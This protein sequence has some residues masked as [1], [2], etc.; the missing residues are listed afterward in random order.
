M[1]KMKF[2]SDLFKKNDAHSREMA[3]IEGEAKAF[4]LPEEWPLTLLKSI[5]FAGLA[6]LNYH[7]FQKSIPGAWGHGVGF[8]AILSEVYVIYA[9][10]NFSRTA[11]PFQYC[12]GGFGGALLVF[13]I[14]HASFSVGDLMSNGAPSAAFTEYARDYAFRI[15][16]ILL[17]AATVVTAALHPK[18]VI[19]FKQAAAHTAIA[20]SRAETA[21][22]IQQMKDQDLVEEARFSM[23]QAKT[24][25]EQRYIGHI[26][27]H[28]QIEQQK[29]DLVNSISDPALRAEAAAEYGVDPASLK[30]LPDQTSNR[31]H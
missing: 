27:Q 8:T 7:L 10:R 6:V 20:V 14:V 1:L 31:S 15:L 21:S 25:R 26:K 12:L 22:E 28:I 19:R 13:S 17:G 29:I 3:A 18:S 4:K 24:E 23:K 9:S 30:P 2:I 5:F 11:G 16:S